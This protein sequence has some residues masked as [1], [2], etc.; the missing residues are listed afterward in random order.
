MNLSGLAV[1]YWLQKE[2]IPIENLLVVVDDIALPFGTIR[3][4]PKGGDAGHN[5]LRNITDVMGTQDYAR[6]RF[7]IGNDFFPGQQA[8]YV[9]SDWGFEEKKSLEARIEIAVDVIKSFGTIGMQQT[10]NN[11]NNK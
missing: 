6:L 9:L 1:N 2:K 4:K 7:G 10:M 5:G 11:Y 8:D 3:L